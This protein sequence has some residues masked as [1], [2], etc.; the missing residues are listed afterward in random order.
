MDP[1]PMAP[2]C[3]LDETGLR[4]QYERYRRAGAGARVV[5]RSSQRL[6]V[7]LADQVDVRLVDETIAIERECCPFYELGWDPERRRLAVAVSQPSQAPALEAIA[8]ALGLE[9]VARTASD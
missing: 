7:D 9:P 1:L 8:F 3:A 5:E 2:S 4:A 6:V